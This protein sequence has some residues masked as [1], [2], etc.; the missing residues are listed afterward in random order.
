V[1]G[2]QGDS[3]GEREQRLAANEVIFRSA[4]E[5]IKELNERFGTAADDASW[6]CECSD[7]ACVDRLELS[8]RDYARIH[9]D[10]TRFVVKP[11]HADDDIEKVVEEHEGYLVVEK[12]D[13]AGREIAE[14]LAPGS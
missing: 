8:F 13:P 4:N 2:D 14:R 5:R 10:P 11:G 1:T 12:T 7:A 6:L 9:A 3:A